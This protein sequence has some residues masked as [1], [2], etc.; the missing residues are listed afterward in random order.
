[1]RPS[2]DIATD[3][4]HLSFGCGNSSNFNGKIKGQGPSGPMSL[5]V[6]SFFRD[7]P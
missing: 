1:M 7:Q 2:L 5:M 4:R 3:I 6:F